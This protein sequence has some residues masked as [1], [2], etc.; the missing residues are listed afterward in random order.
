MSSKRKRRGPT[1]PKPP[2]FEAEMEEIALRM[3][4]LARR[5]F[6]SRPYSRDVV[7]SLPPV[8]LRW[9]L[10]FRGRA[11]EDRAAGRRILEELTRHIDDAILGHAAFRPGR[12]YCFFCETSDC[13]HAAPRTPRDVFAGFGQT[14]QPEWKPFLDL[15]IDRRLEG[16]DRLS[17]GTS[18]PIQLLMEKEELVG[19]RLEAFSRGDRAYDLRGQLTLGYFQ[20]PNG[21]SGPE[22]F[23]VTLQ[24]VR[25]S[26]RS[27]AVRLGLNVLG[28]LPDGRDVRELLDGS[29]DLV[30]LDLV[31]DAGGRLARINQDLK[32]RKPKERPE[33]AAEAASRLLRDMAQGFGR[34]RRRRIWRTEHARERALEKERPTGMARSDLA[35]ARPERSFRDRRDK[36][37]IVLGPKGRV[38]VFSD[39]GLHVTSLQLDRRSLDARIEKK[40]WR[41]LDPAEFRDV[42]ERAEAAFRAASPEPDAPS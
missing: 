14:G 10:D 6:L 7:R 42:L 28:R 34:R 20:Q 1:T 4:D 21:E 26:T 17:E 8:E 12:V 38:H 37:F 31:H 24:L 16:V 18:R 29:R 2:D 33:R 19:D 22:R 32:R 41:P 3:A 35:S 15:A 40:R 9:P 36:T 30:F 5:I 13:E 23:A 27:R 25:S 11:K 39:E